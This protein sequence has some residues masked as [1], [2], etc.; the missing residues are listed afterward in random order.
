MEGSSI[1]EIAREILQSTI[2]QRTRQ[3]CRVQT[4][5]KFPVKIEQLTAKNKNRAKTAERAQEDRES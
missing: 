5:V 2:Y 4:A 3:S 1:I